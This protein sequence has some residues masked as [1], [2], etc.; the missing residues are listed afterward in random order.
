M[1][2]SKDPYD[3]YLLHVFS[4]LMDER[5]V[6][7]TATRLERSTYVIGAALDRLRVI[8]DDPLLLRDGPR[9]LPTERALQ[10]Q[11]SLQRMLGDVGTSKPRSAS[12]MPFV[13][14]LMAV[15][16]QRMRSRPQGTWTPSRRP[17]AARL[18]RLS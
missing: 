7:R 5:S 8:F 13:P 3:T 10:L 14:P 6:S 1:S 11:D 15:A 4:T 12:P 9:L 17:A 16:V 18:V 2:R